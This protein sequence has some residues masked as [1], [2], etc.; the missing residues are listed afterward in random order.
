MTT[1]TWSQFAFV[2]FGAAAIRLYIHGKMLTVCVSGW[3]IAWLWLGSC[4]VNNM[5]YYSMYYEIERTHTHTH[6][7]HMCTVSVYRDWKWIGFDFG[8]AISGGFINPNSSFII[9]IFRMTKR[10]ARTSSIYQLHSELQQ[11]A[12]RK[13]RRKPNNPKIST[14]TCNNFWAA[15]FKMQRRIVRI[16]RMNDLRYTYVYSMWLC[17]HLHSPPTPHERCNI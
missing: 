9:K 11:C 2:A 15:Q 17:W 7:V 12:P 5:L 4:C 6:P 10:S 3:R 13:T 8:I 1:A 14:T 16:T